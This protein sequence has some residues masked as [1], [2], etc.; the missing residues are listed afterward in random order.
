MNGRL[1]GGPKCCLKGCEN[2]V[3]IRKFDSLI[4]RYE[5]KLSPQELTDHDDVHNLRVCNKHYSSL[6]ST[7]QMPA[8]GKTQSKTRSDAYHGILKVN[9]CIVQCSQSKKKM[10]VFPVTFPA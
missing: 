6:A 2:D 8:K 4:G 9:P 1:T 7:G 10:S 5:L 3:G